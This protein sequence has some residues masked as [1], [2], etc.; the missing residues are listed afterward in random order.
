MQTLISKNL[1]SL[2]FKI[3]KCEKLKTILKP[4]Q[5]LYLYRYF[6]L[7]FMSKLFLKIIPISGGSGTEN[8]EYITEGTRHT[9][10]Y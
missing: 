5:Q 4:I 10:K 7:I 9:Q 3:I 8:R 6:I 1:F 2:H